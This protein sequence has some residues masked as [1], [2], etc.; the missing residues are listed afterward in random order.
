MLKQPQKGELPKRNEQPTYLQP[1]S[2]STQKT[3]EGLNP[4]SMQP[5]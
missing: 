4:H 1:D 3:T 2:Q 5:L